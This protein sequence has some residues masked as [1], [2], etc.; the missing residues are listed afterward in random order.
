[1]ITRCD[2]L[3]LRQLIENGT[4]CL[5]TEIDFI[6]S[7]NVY[8]V[9]DGD[10]GTNMFLTM[11]AALREIST[12]SDHAAS[13]VA[14]ALAHGSLMGARGNSGVILSQVWRGMAKH[15]DGKQYLTASDLALA[16]HE[17]AVTAYKGVM[18]PVEGTI[19]TVAR[20][21]AEAAMLAAAERDDMVYVVERVVQQ[22]EDALGRTPDLLPVLKEAGVVDAGGRG[23]YAIL[24]GMRRY[25]RGER[26][27][28]APAARLGA[29]LEE[30][31]PV[32]APEHEYGYDVQFLI[33][34]RDL[35]IEE[36]RETITSM[37][38]SALVVG[39]ANTL[40]VHVHSDDP[41]RIISYATSKGALRDVVVED[42]Q[43][44]YR[45]FLAKQ[46]ETQVIAASV[47]EPLSD[48]A[49]VAVANGEGLQ[50]VFE[51]LG[52]AAVVPGGQTMNPSTEE[53]LTAMS[54]LSTD[55]VILLPNNP[56]IIL[57]AEQAQRMADQEV[58]VVPTTT[59]PQGISA[60]LAFNYQSDLKTNA[61]LME[62]AASQIQTIEITTAIRS[63]H[64]N[65]LRI[66][67]G[68]FIGLLNGELVEA[69]NN[70]QQVT[71]AVLQRIDIARYEI[72]TVYWGEDITKE[73]AEELA[74]WIAGH[75][76]DKEV[77]LVE[78][79]Q[80]HYRYIISAE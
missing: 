48:V 61:D 71:Q 3:E 68:Q 72:I 12:V 21:A 1:V 57:A 79:K 15:L 31:E 44:Q 53:L 60:L 6:N 63:V 7:L 34:G 46:G 25:W 23:L 56:N 11:Q 80:P 43:E 47:S 20:E 67:E 13:S 36:I 22:A 41:G 9:P 66:R 54:A 29:R 52:A 4:A 17:G 40:K 8:P 59:I 69:G 74:S 18:R 35:P 70:L 77:E 16:L 58:V 76:R 73:Q 28:S 49:V 64:I 55:K 65:G 32:H 14:E 42:M 50:R 37:G 51:S 19:L 30:V 27:T 24:E 75:Y 62:R 39:D 45:Q 10:T 2:G 26:V 38:D 78:G 5:E 33:D